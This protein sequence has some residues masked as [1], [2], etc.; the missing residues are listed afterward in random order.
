MWSRH[1]YAINGMIFSFFSSS[2]GVL[3]C[4]CWRNFPKIG[5]SF[6]FFVIT[7]RLSCKAMCTIITKQHNCQ[8]LVPKSVIQ[9]VRAAS[10]LF[11]VVETGSFVSWKI[12]KLFVW[13]CWTI[14]ISNDIL[15]WFFRL[16]E[17]KSPLTK[18]QAKRNF[19]F[20]KWNFVHSTSRRVSRTL[21]VAAFNR[22]E[23]FFARNVYPNT[24]P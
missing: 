8:F 7:T 22:L 11:E 14:H 24:L 4:D 2:L 10:A 9:H 20:F 19:L 21:I 13:A 5:D 23:S 16:F 15:N 6:A 18:L 1:D 17:N 12:N 3:D